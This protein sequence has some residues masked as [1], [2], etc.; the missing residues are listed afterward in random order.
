[1]RVRGFGE[2]GRINMEQKMEHEMETW[3]IQSSW[4]KILPVRTL[5]K[6]TYESDCYAHYEPAY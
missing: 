4:F 6:Y 5:S 2:D 1:M 3:F